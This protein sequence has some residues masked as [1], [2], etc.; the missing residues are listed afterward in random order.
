[1]DELINRA[2]HA[3]A[4]LLD[5]STLRRLVYETLYEL[6]SLDMPI[7]DAKRLLWYKIMPH[8]DYEVLTRRL[9]AFTYSR[10]KRYLSQ[11]DIS[12]QV[13]DVLETIRTTDS[14]PTSTKITLF[15]YLCGRIRGQISNR[16]RQAYVKARV[17][18]YALD[19]LGAYSIDTDSLDKDKKIKFLREIK[20][21]IKEE[22]RKHGRL[23]AI[24]EFYLEAGLPF[25]K[26]C[27]PKAKYTLGVLTGKGVELS[28]NDIYKENGK[29]EKLFKNK[30]IEVIE[31]IKRKT[32]Q[33]LTG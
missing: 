3:Y 24:S 14:W 1:M 19:E 9:R 23:N 18:D 5:E 11:E 20:E 16:R 4:S 2:R 27:R 32:D 26:Q 8:L 13:Q 17:N 29:L 31:S 15:Q 21:V 10:Y 7:E 12:D 28:I 33:S 6:D 25:P 22:L 30:V